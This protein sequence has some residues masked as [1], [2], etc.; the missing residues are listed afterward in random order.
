[1]FFFTL[2]LFFCCPFFIEHN[3]PSSLFRSRVSSNG[4]QQQQQQHSGG[5]K[6]DLD[7]NEKIHKLLF[8]SNQIEIGSSKLIFGPVYSASDENLLNE[9]VDVKQIE[10]DDCSPSFDSFACNYCGN[11]FS[12]YIDLQLHLKTHF[13]SKL[14]LYAFPSPLSS[15]LPLILTI[16]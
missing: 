3:K 10:I 16:S 7:L 13:D 12:A 1:L 14:F 4:N 2:K 6:N 9:V 5:A 15:V 8:S 11:K